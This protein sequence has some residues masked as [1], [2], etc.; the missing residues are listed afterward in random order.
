MSVRG[1]A[2]ATV[3]SPAARSRRPGSARGARARLRVE[4]TPRAAV[5]GDAAARDARHVFREGRRRQRRRRQRLTSRR[6]RVDG[7]R[8]V[9]AV[10]AGAQEVHRVRENHVHVRGRRAPRRR[11]DDRRVDLRRRPIHVGAVGG[12]GSRDAAAAEAQHERALR[13][14]AGERRGPEPPACSRRGSRR[15]ILASARAPPTGRPCRTCRGGATRRPWRSPRARRR[16]PRRRSPRRPRGRVELGQRLGGAR[17]PAP[18][19]AGLQ[20]PPPGALPARG[21][22]AVERRAAPVRG[23]QGCA[24]SPSTLSA[25]P[26]APPPRRGDGAGARRL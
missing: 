19:A 6:S 25:G 24:A 21:A 2:A 15:G 9:G 23:S 10:V 13:C 20:K 5:R 26:F 7:D 22:L 17:G 3:F 14:R 8:A 1:P 18:A 12:A 16:R 4:H 11:R